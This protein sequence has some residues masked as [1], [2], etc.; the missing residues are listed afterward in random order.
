MVDSLPAK[1]QYAGIVTV[2]ISAVPVSKITARQIMFKSNIKLL[3]LPKVIK[4]C[5]VIR[6]HFLMNCL[7]RHCT[8]LYTLLEFRVHNQKTEVRK[9]THK[10]HVMVL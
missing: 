1:H 7:L 5:N 4:T 8:F 9:M 3:G 10:S 2:R 6:H